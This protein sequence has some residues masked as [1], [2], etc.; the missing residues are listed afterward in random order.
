MCSSGVDDTP[1]EDSCTSLP[2]SAAELRR[3]F[4]PPRLPPL[5]AAE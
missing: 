4:I 1:Q 2:L 5:G 3:G